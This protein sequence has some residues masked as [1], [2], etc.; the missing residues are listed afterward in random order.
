MSA[1]QRSAKS[2]GVAIVGAGRMGELRGHIAVTHPSVNFVACAD[3]DPTRAAHVAEKIGAQFHSGDNLAVISRPEVNAVIVSSAEDAHVE[4]VIAALE[5]G[6]PVLCEKPIGLSLDAADEVLAA[7]ERFG[8]N[9]RYG[10]S[11]R[12]RHRYLRTKEQIVQGRLG[13]IVG[14]HGRAYNL[15][16]QSK[17]ADI[18]A[19]GLSPVV[20]SLTYYVDLMCWLL[21]GNPVVEV[22]ARGIGL[23]K[24][25]SRGQV[26]HDLTWAT[27]THADGAIVNLG[28]YYSLPEAYPSRGLS[29]RVELVGT[30]GVIILDGDHADQI[31]Y[32]ERGVPHVHLP[33][34]D[35]N[36]LF[37][38]SSTPGSWALGD[39][40]GPLADETRA[41]LD[42]LV[43]GRPCALTTAREARNNLEI[44]LA[45]DRSAHERRALRLPIER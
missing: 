4:P 3:R 28:I 24:P 16:A 45:I 41:W 1:A 6:K 18:R 27:L 44:T 21:E 12:F 5:L 2:L 37:L 30:E 29:S 34:Q 42:H 25:D 35:A 40:W 14:G 20:Y 32:S 9:V 26:K 33:N 38:G 31:M 7:I 43:T 13:K 39:F 22:T 8:G 10:Y 17:Q 19:P 36:L 23:G 11:R 15:R